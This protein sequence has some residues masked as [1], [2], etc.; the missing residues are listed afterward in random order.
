MDRQSQKYMPHL[1]TNPHVGS[2][3]IEMRTR[4]MHTLRMRTSS[5]LCEH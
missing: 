3:V 4:G 5:I 1:L 2:K